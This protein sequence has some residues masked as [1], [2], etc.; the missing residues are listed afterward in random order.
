MSDGEFLLSHEIPN[1]TD[2]NLDMFSSSMRYQISS[3]VSGTHIVTPS[4][5]RSIEETN[6]I[7]KGIDPT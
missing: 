2:V 6:F 3:K 1:K 7:Q 5:W 4:N